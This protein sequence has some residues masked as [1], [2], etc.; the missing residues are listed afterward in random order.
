MNFLDKFEHFIERL[1]GSP[2]ARAFSSTLH[3]VEILGALKKEMDSRATIVS[4][5]RILARHSYRILIAESDFQRLERIKVE[6]AAKLARGLKNYAAQRFYY[7]SSTISVQLQESRALNKGVMEIS[8]KPPGPIIWVPR[9]IFQGVSYTITKSSTVIGRASDADIGANVRGLSRHHAEIRWDGKNA[10][11]IDL[12]SKNGT[13]L[14]GKIVKKAA[15]PERCFIEVGKTRILFEIVPHTKSTY[16]QL[17]SPDPQD[18]K[19]K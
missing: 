6:L 19:R 15:V 3:P 13:K 17:L 14:E 18:R 2:F 7:L 5:T 10:V 4:R 9:L 12:A 11:L 1:V 16:Q 8:S